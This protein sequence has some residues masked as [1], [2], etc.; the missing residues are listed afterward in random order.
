MSENVI[1]W[2]ETQTKKGGSKNMD[3]VDMKD[4]EKDL[5]PAKAKTKNKTKDTKQTMVAKDPIEQEH[6]G[7]CLCGCGAPLNK[8]RKF[9]MGHDAKLASK[10]KKIMKGEMDRTEIPETTWKI[11]DD[12][13]VIAKAKQHLADAEA[14]AKAKAEAKMK[15]KPEKD[16]PEK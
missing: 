16:N 1:K 7:Y 12:L 4:L 14:K 5:A 10:Y 2:K 15:A 11:I 8:G 9:K 3:A 13:P 6:H